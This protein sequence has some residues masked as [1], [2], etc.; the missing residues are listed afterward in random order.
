V[1]PRSQPGLIVGVLAFAACCALA[2]ALLAG[3]SGAAVTTSA[4]PTG[5][6]TLSASPTPAWP[7]PQG[8]L[9][10]SITILRSGFRSAFSSGRTGVPFR[11]SPPSVIAALERYFATVDP[12]EFNGAS[13]VAFIWAFTVPRE[14][15]GH[16]STATRQYVEAYFL[17]DGEHMVAAGSM[18]AGINAQFISLS[19]RSSAAAWHVEGLY[20]P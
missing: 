4:S 10:I 13:R 16:R 7:A 12:A 5:A 6:T 11:A 20:Y 2:I 14:P 15:D 1:R 19:R 3:C 8:D 18:A 17:A 9:S